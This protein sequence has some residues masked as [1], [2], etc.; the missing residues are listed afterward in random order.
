MRVQIK[1]YGNDARR[2]IQ[3]NLTLPSNMTEEEAEA[4]IQELTAR[5]RFQDLS[6]KLRWNGNENGDGDA[7]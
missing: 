6:S 2:L 7:D 5:V 4:L 1:L 3:E